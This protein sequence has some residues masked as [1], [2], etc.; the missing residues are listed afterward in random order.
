M[1]RRAKTNRSSVPLTTLPGTVILWAGP[2]LMTNMLFEQ[3]DHVAPADGW[4]RH[5]DFP[6]SD[7]G[8]VTI[9]GGR[10]GT[11]ASDRLPGWVG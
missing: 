6:A 1:S 2:S 4:T 3:A 7:P 8:D 10:D 11:F 5:G 9:I